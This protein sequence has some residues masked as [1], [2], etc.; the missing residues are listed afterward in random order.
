MSFAFAAEGRAI[1]R[2]RFLPRRL[3]DA[4]AAVFDALNCL[5]LNLNARRVLYGILAF[6]NSRTP[7][8]EI[9]PRRDTLRAESLLESDSSLYRGLSVLETKGYISREQRRLTRSGKFHVSPILL[10]QKALTL[11][12][13][14]KVI[15]KERSSNLEDGHIREHTKERKQSYQNTTDT[16]DCKQKAKTGFQDGLPSDLAVLRKQGI[17]KAGICWLMGLATKHG[18][19]LSDVFACV[20]HRVSTLRSREAVAYLRSMIV[21]EIDYAWIAKT[22][23]EGAVEV[24]KEEAARLR[25]AALDERYAGFEVHSA[26]GDYLGTL[27]M[28]GQDHS[29]RMAS[30]SGSMP[31]N[32]KFAKALLAEQ[33][34]LIRV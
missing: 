23:T 2:A 30:G 13:L 3:I 17:S 31:V 15:H 34:R 28:A 5:D 6:A 10:T 33:I 22:R 21:R 27:E 9:F 29:L 7:S 25:L 20:S 14:D 12:G 11:L 4:R 32:L 26:N 8:K 18:K 16:T 1:V 19:R 24:L